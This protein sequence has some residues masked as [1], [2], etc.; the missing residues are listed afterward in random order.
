M[1]LA[2][3][4]QQGYV[5]LASTAERKPTPLLHQMVPPEVCA[6][7]VDT[8]HRVPLP[9]PRALSDI[10]VSLPVPRPTQTASLVT[11]DSTAPGAPAPMLR[12]RVLLGTTVKEGL[13]KPHNLKH[14]KGITRWPAPTNRSLVLEAGTSLQVDLQHVFSARKVG[15]V[16][17]VFCSRPSC[18]FDLFFLCIFLSRKQLS[19]QIF[20]KK[21]EKKTIKDTQ[22]VRRIECFLSLVDKTAQI[23]IKS[24]LFFIGY[25]ET[26]ISHEANGKSELAFCYIQA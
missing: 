5:M 14:L 16:L 11:Q 26:V 21:R 18:C 17:D 19:L 10:T 3:Q 24:A 25:R 12:S 1:A 4:S 20:K 2:A 15:V 7:R 22:R 8:A 9:Q 23:F 13:G 6:Q